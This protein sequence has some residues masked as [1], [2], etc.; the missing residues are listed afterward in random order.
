VLLLLLINAGLSTAN[1]VR[2]ILGGKGETD[3]YA[4]WYYGHY[5][6]EGVNPYR[7]FYE[8]VELSGPLTH[9]DGVTLD[10][11]PPI[12]QGYSRFPS[13]SPAMVLLLT[14]LSFFSWPVARVLWAACNLA[15]MLA[16]PWL[17]IRL[18]PKGRRLTWPQ[19]GIICL[20]FYG[21]QGVPTAISVG[22]TTFLVIAL[23]LG[24][25]LALRKGWLL[26]GLL[27]GLALSKYTVSLPVLLLV[28]YQ[29]RWRVAA[30][31]L[32]V[33]VLAVVAVSGLDAPLLAATGYFQRVQILVA[34]PGI[35]L[36]DLLQIRGA[37]VWGV[38]AAFTLAVFGLLW[39]WWR[40]ARPRGERSDA[41][42]FTDW[43]LLAI[44]VFWALLFIY[45]RPYDTPVTVVF[46]ALVVCGL[47]NPSL[48]NLSETARVW[49]AVFLGVFIAAMSLPT[50]TIERLLPGSL[51]EAWPD[52]ARGTMTAAL[53]L[54]LGCTFWLLRRVREPAA[55]PE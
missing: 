20:A 31:A 48:W 37:A 38:T 23:M 2:D 7:T 21:F 30:T 55:A 36:A 8:P 4:Y 44:L 15:L 22:Q 53:L 16:I 11:L 18:L 1:A 3:V 39:V 49:L 27:L 47:A 29:R 17:A 10:A 40:G 32:V 35:H 9:L 14:P 33:Q 52:V 50:G 41:I 26:P 54:A 45:H 24:T 25:L 34:G 42:T 28:L 13:N 5:V 6:R 51:A 46:V 12:P 19:K 43:H